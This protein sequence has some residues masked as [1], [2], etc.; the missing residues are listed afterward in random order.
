[1]YWIRSAVKR[2]QRLHETYQRVTKTE[3]RLREEF[4]REPTKS[5]LAEA[6]DIT[7]IQ[8]DRCRRAMQQASFS[9]DAEVQNN[10]K[11][12]SSTTRKDTMYD[13]VASKVDESEYEKTQ[14]SLMKE[15]LIST[16]RRYLSPHEVDLLLLRYGLMDERA[17]PKGLSGPLTIAGAS[18]EKVS[19]T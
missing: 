8:L 1:M 19:K 11:P 18:K 17:L 15:H 16:L 9:L 6:C 2:S 12:N 14:Q 5:E 7:V 13:I 3:A 4:G 10:F